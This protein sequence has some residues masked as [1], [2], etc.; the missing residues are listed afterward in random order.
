[1]NVPRRSPQTG[2]PFDRLPPELYQTRIT[3]DLRL[4]AA[5]PQTIPYEVVA[6]GAE[7]E[8]ASLA[9]LLAARKN[10]PQP[11]GNLPLV[12]LTRGVEWSQGLH[13]THASLAALSANS[14]HQVVTAA[15]HEIHLFRPL[16]RG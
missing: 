6:A 9:L 5:Q 7:T 11:L 1:V 2:T 8:R 3:L 15:G 16:R 14:R 10:N 12:V 13:D 4:I